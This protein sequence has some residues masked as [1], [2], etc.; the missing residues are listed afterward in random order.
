MGSSVSH[1][2]SIS[3]WWISVRKSRSP[4]T[5]RL[6][7]TI[8][9]GLSLLLVLVAGRVVGQNN[10]LIRKL[11]GTEI[12]RLNYDKEGHL[13]S[14]Q[15]FRISKLDSS[16]RTLSVKMDIQLLIRKES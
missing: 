12:K 7:R 5:T 3:K 11:S 9:L 4:K 1:L 6:R 13:E 10:M 15:F 8:K 2:C 16:R 14:K